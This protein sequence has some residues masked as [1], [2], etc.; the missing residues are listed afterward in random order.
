MVH[1]RCRRAASER[2]PSEATRRAPRTVIFFFSSRR[3][4]TRSLRDW[5]SDVCSSDLAGGVG[6][7]AGLAIENAVWGNDKHGRAVVGDKHVG[8]GG[9]RANIA[10]ERERE[11][12]ILSAVGPAE[13]RKSVV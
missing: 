12:E 11:G 5:S 7:R 3:R 2:E 4:H 9:H 8:R 13:D 1:C 10:A 6:G